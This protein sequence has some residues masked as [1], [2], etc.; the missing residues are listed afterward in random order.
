MKSR[1]ALVF[2]AL[3]A[4]AVLALAQPAGAASHTGVN[5]TSQVSNAALGIT[6][7][8]QAHAYGDTAGA[9]SGSCRS[10]MTPAT[11]ERP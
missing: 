6:L 3:I 1:L 4:A 8:V 10:R 11:S 5:I 9:L 7:A 2:F